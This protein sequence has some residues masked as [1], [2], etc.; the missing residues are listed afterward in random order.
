MLNLFAAPMWLCTRRSAAEAP[1]TSTAMASTSTPRN[2]CDDR[3]L[4]NRDRSVRR[5]T[6]Q[7]QPTR[8]VLTGTVYGVE[9]LVRWQHPTLGLLQ[10]DEF[11]PLAERAGLI[12]PLTRTVLDLAIH[13][14]A[15][16]HRS[17]HALQM[18]VNIS[19]WDLNGPATARLDLSHA[20]VVPPSG[21]AI[22]PRGHRVMPD[23]R[24]SSGEEKSRTVAIIRSQDLHR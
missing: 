15:R 21:G 18:S 5:L 1:C 20:R 10:P 6:L 14:L 2:A 11:I 23:P 12:M 17:G 8:H 13:E 9:A 3:R 16:L 4:A 24:P 19:Q 7:F 22:S